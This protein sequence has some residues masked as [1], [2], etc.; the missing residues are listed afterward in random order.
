MDRIAEATVGSGITE[1]ELL[2]RARARTLIPLNQAHSALARAY[3]EIP[4]EAETS[5][6][7]SAPT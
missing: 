3:G 5:R 7:E 2:R 4:R 6:C 1:D